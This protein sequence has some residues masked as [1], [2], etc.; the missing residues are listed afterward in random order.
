MNSLFRPFGLRGDFSLEELVKNLNLDDWSGNE[1]LLMPVE[2]EKTSPLVMVDY[3]QVPKDRADRLRKDLIFHDWIVGSK[4]KKGILSWDIKCWIDEDVLDAVQSIEIN[5]TKILGSSSRGEKSKKR[6][7]SSPITDYKG[8]ALKW[9]KGCSRRSPIST[10]KDTSKE[11]TEATPQSP[12]LRGVQNMP[13]SR[14]KV[15][16]T[17]RRVCT[18]KRSWAPSKRQLLI[19]SMF[20]PKQ[21]GPRGDEEDS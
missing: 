2:K 15:N 7:K 11:G 5:V 1:N 9:W 20:S 16:K 10:S 8:S 6:K 4:E 3:I 12:I 19:D 21:S 13:P 14:G 18:P 17:R